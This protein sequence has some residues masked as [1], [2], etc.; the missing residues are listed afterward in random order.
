MKV[1]FIDTVHPILWER[2]EENGFKC[3]DSTHISKDEFLNSTEAQTCEGLVIRSRF[4]LFAEELKR[5]PNLNF[6]AR[7]GAGLE[8]IDLDYCAAQ[9][10]KV[11]NSPEGNMTAVA[12]HAIGMI[13]SL[14]N[15][16]KRGDAEVKEALWNREENRGLELA[17]KTVGIIGY[18]NMGSA[19]AKRLQGFECETIAYDKYKSGFSSELVQEVSLEKLFQETDILSLHIPI[20]EE[21]KY[22]VDSEFIMKF[23][24]PFFLINTARGNHVKISDLLEA[25]D[26]EKIKGACLDV[27]EYEK[28]NFETIH[29]EDLPDEWKELVK[30]ENVLLSPHVAGWTLESYE[31]LSSFL[32]DKILKDWT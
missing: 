17:G 20:S 22:Y 23:R 28:F 29:P 5:L 2:L 19:L 18:G 21:T 24:K 3:I 31:K 14:F 15:H 26:E 25:L 16:L 12:E 1:H 8:N 4:K 6:I 13:L 11:Y 10:I 27:L 32:A 30:R 9:N 7:S